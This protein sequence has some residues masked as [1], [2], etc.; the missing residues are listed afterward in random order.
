LL[1][2]KKLSYNEVVNKKRVELNKAEKGKP[3]DLLLGLKEKKRSGQ[4]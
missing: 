4:F 1:P 2:E 3:L